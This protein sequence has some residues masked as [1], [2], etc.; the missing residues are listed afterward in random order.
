M[1]RYA[2]TAI[3]K[4]GLRHLALNNWAKNHRD[5]KEE[6]DAWLRQIV[7]ANS[8]EQIKELIGEDL[9]VT[10]VECYDGSGEAMG[11]IIP[12]TKNK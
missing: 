3:K 5:T 9:Q 6:G 12:E 7:D 11:T 4:D 1:I 2:I 8:P 10:P